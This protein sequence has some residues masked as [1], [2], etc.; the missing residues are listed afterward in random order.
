MYFESD[1][2]VL[3]AGAPAWLVTLLTIVGALPLA[4]TALGL[5]FKAFQ[6]P[7]AK[8]LSDACM[9]FGL[10]FVKLVLAVRA[11][12]SSEPTEPTK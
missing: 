12:F 6:G 2:V 3:P 8:A 9:A 11:M 4:F 7:K 10:D 1:P 5:F